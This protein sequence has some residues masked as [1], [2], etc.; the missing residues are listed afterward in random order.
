V[1]RVNQ[2][3]IAKKL[4]LSRPTVSRSLANHPA[5]SADTR[6]KVQ[7][8]ASELGYGKSPARTIRRSR[9]ARP[10]T[11][12]VLIGAPLVASDR[13]TFPQ[14]LQG[15]RGRAAIEHASIDVLP[16]ALEAL[17][18]EAGQREILRHIRNADWRGVVL[19]YP[20]APL[21]VAMLSEKLSAVSVLTEYQDQA[22]DVVDT[23]HDGVRAFVGRLAALGHR[24]IGF[25]SWHYPVGGLWASRRC[26][27]YAEGIL[28]EGLQLN[29]DWILN[30]HATGPR[31]E[32]PATLAD[33]AAEL[34]RREGVTAFVCAADHQAYQLIRDLSVRG[35]E[36]PA[37]CSITGFDGNEPPPGLPPLAT[38]AVPN[39]DIGASAIA[40]LLSRL[41][42]PGSS[43]RKILVQTRPVEGATLAAP[44]K[45]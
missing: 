6:R 25:V 18:P 34:C 5:I 39:E 32:T 15:I 13:S 35:L 4:R 42:H 41:L 19:I 11:L 29:P 7:E 21:T 14:I 8:M 17:S 30:I 31:Y 36:V 22:I 16:L 12:G 33:R 23:D 24:R 3:L 44:R 43:Q 1:P 28:Q 2:Q 20:F 10:I 27:A 9:Q 37:D 38:L 45:L 26:A 40:R